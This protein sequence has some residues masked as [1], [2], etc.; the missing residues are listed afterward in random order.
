MEKLS[1]IFTK[2][3]IRILELISREPLHLRHIAL[4]LKCSPAKVHAAITTFKEHALVLEAKEKNKMVYSF[5]PHSA[6]GKKILHFLE[7][8]MPKSAESAPEVIELF[9]QISPLDFRYCRSSD[10][11]AQLQP[12]LTETAF[13]RY[14]A[15]V[16]AALAAVLAQRKI[17]SRDIAQE[18]SRAA[19]SI[20]AHE[21][22]ATEEKIKHNMRAVANVIRSKV[23]ES[24]RPYVHFTTTSYDIIDT[25][26]AARY[27][28]F[29]NYVLLP[30]LRDLEKTLIAIALREKST[31]QVGR[32]HGQHASPVTFGFAIAHYVSRLGGRILAIRKAADNLRGKIAGAVGSYNASSLFISDVQQFEREVLAQ[33]KLKPSPTSTQVVEPEFMTDYLHSIISCFGVLANLSDDMRHLQRSEI[34]EVGEFFEA[35]QVGSSTMPQKRNPINFENVKSMWKFCM[36]HMTTAYMDQISEHQRDLTN[37]AS[38]RFIPELLAAFYVSVVR[39]NKTM[40]KLVVDTNHLQKNLEQNSHLIIAEPLYL[41]LASQ[42]HPDGHE[43][44]RQLTLQS[45]KTGKSLMML[46]KQER[47]LAVYLAKF[48]KKQMGLLQN[49]KKYTGI[50]E[51]KT[52]KICEFWS[53]KLKI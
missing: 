28:D 33:L 36:P 37:S 14:A 4:R 13:V 23:S 50:A 32:T 27:K 20:T 5:N 39:L 22:Y 40:R 53:V 8:P 15:R 10:I 6:L 51:Q 38:M 41:L 16:E 46:A 17:C 29:T 34:A 18:I 19:N 1:R 47:S 42:G 31:V 48:T 52:K 21:V 26:N 24:A 43:V 9:S 35:Q 25:A 3:N 45:Q 7:Q 49:P 11:H 44:I 12:Y 30:A 2:T